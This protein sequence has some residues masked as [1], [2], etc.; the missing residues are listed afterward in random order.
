MPNAKP[1]GVETLKEDK[2]LNMENRRMFS[3]LK[4]RWVA[5]DFA[6]EMETIK[7]ID[8][9]SNIGVFLSQMSHHDGGNVTVHPTRIAKHVLDNTQPQFILLRMKEIMMW[10]ADNMDRT[11]THY[12][13]K[14]TYNTRW[15]MS[16]KPFQY[17][18]IN[19]STKGLA[20]VIQSNQF[21]ISS[22]MFDNSYLLNHENPTWVSWNATWV[23]M[24][25]Q[26]KLERAVAKDKATINQASNMATHMSEHIEYLDAAMD[27]FTTVMKN[28]IET[29]AENV[30]GYTH[31][32]SVREL[33]RA[34]D[35]SHYMSEHLLVDVD[36][37]L[38]PESKQT[39]VASNKLIKEH[40]QKLFAQKLQ[41]MDMKERFLALFDAKDGEEE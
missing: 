21:W 14:S 37:L 9:P 28:R 13:D 41:L 38:F 2:E 40:T 7:W 17:K 29:H 31:N 30:L 15:R 24:L 11:F 19:W 12:Q 39:V 4:S 32:V 18:R 26:M 23:S 33:V 5:I 36:S 1:K 22:T 20:S 25:P 16:A 3:T 27:K 10:F 8:V 35:M 6:T 34:D